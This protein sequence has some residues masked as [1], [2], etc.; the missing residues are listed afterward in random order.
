MISVM[1]YG[2]QGQ[3]HFAHDDIFVSGG[4]ATPEKYMDIFRMIFKQKG[5][6]AHYKMMM[7]EAY[8]EEP[9]EAA[10]E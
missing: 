1:G 4:D 6:L 10:A 7:G 3:A 9:E 8:I 5:Q 2:F